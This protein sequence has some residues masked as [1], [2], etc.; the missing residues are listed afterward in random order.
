MKLV[1]DN[2][3]RRVIPRWREATAS[4]KDK[5]LHPLRVRTRGPDFS[6]EVVRATAELASNPTAPV[7][8]D[9]LNV[10]AMSGNE[11]LARAARAVIAS[12]DDLP[13]A[14]QRG[15]L[16]SETEEEGDGDSEASTSRHSRAGIQR[17]RGLLKSYPN[18]PLL[19]LDLARHHAILG[20]HEKAETAARTSLAL[21]PHHRLV[22]RS[23]ARCFM[24]IGEKGEEQAHR[25]LA[26]ST[27]T[28]HDPWLIAAELAIAQETGR[29]PR[30][31]RDAKAMLKSQSHLPA[32]LSE[33][34]SAVGTFEVL[35][36]SLKNAKKAF[37]IALIDPTENALAQVKWAERRT[38][39][40]F[41]IERWLGE[42]PSAHEALYMR[43]YQEGDLRSAARHAQ[44]WYYDEPFSA[45]ASVTAS[46]VC[47]MLDDY[48]SVMEMSN[49]ALIAQPGNTL[50][51]NNRIFARISGGGIFAQDEKAIDEEI[52]A[53]AHQLIAQI[54]ARD[55]DTTHAAANLGLLAYRCGNPLEGRMAYDFAIGWARER[56]E[57]F[58]VANAALFHAREAIL[59]NAEW[60]P[61]LLAEAEAANTKVLSSGINFYM[62]KV[63]ALAKAPEKAAEILS[64]ENFI[65][66]RI[67]KPTAPPKFEVRKDKNGLLTLILPRKL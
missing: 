3:D 50:L 33:L 25:L 28:V 10:A 26:D 22:L 59:A 11:A 30:Y 4:A 12:T 54:Q 61:E 15:L 24:N 17:I 40:S 37:E 39:G 36:G 13:P 6:D 64:P 35:D 27:A 53:L 52:N 1:R 47:S 21:A 60:A 57:W 29:S 9:A 14:V 49:T 46:Y 62:E 42:F 55:K 58:S 44:C 38:S 2:F 20:H 34:A 5:T 66:T 18:N 16:S 8:V 31:W 19:F 7:A 23:V 43:A 48:A 56:K 45:N 32:N 67:A 51:E 63:R 41:A 65:Y